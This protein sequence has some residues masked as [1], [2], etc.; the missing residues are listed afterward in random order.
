MKNSS[1]KDM[2]WTGWKLQTGNRYGYATPCAVIIAEELPDW[3]TVCYS[4]L[5]FFPLLPPLVLLSFFLRSTPPLNPC[6]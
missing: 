1:L 4:S 2:N 6:S 3:K 5:T